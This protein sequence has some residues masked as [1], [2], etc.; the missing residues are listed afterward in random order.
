MIVVGVVD[1]E[2]VDG[3]GWGG[4]GLLLVLLMMM[5]QTL[6]LA[7][8]VVVLTSLSPQPLSAL[9]A[10][11]LYRGSGRTAESEKGYLTNDSTA[12][13]FNE[14]SEMY[15]LEIITAASS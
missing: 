14:I 13:R 7:E 8:Y 15:C 11:S 10:L 3:C 9:Q 5:R 2:G 6:E 4:V 12:S 1:W